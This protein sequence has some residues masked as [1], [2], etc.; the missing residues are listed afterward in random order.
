MSFVDL[1]STPPKD[2]YPAWSEKIVERVN[3]ALSLAWARIRA[4]CPAVIATKDEDTITNQLLTELTLMRKNDEPPGF[5]SNFFGVPIRDG[6]LPNQSGDSIDQMPDLT[7]YLAHPRLGVADDRLDALFYECKVLKSWSNLNLYRKNGIRRFQTG[8]Y[9]WRMPHAGMIGYVFDAAPK[10]PV[11]ALTTYFSKKVKEITVG[12]T[13]GCDTVPA[14]A[15]NSPNAD[16]SDIA[17]T[18]HTRISSPNQIELCHLWF[19]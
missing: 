18:I 3:I 8:Q 7:I 11:S 17:R 13:L 10:C 16:T 5:N 19:F 15:M 9:A 4:N 1:G 2:V 6:K 14:L 12:A